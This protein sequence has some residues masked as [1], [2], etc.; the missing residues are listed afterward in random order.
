MKRRRRSS[1]RQVDHVFERDLQSRG[2][3]EKIPRDAAQ[4]FFQVLLEMIGA[5]YICV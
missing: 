5:F 1:S 4:I 3:S 2:G